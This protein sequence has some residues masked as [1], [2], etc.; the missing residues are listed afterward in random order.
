MDKILYT[1]RDIRAWL[2][3][4]DDIL[5]PP[6]DRRY[7]QG[8]IRGNKPHDGITSGRLTTIMLRAALEDLPRPLYRVAVLR[9]VQAKPLAVTLRRL[10]LTKDQ[11]YYRCDKAVECITHYCN[12]EHD[13][14][15]DVARRFS[16]SA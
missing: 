4:L 11:Y 2:S 5:D 7:G 1:Q 12:G 3:R 9:W 13:K 6:R 10:G 15:L 8:N 16:L 14:L